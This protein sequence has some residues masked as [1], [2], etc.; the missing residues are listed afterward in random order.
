MSAPPS[1]LIGNPTSA[2]D[3]ADGI[4]TVAAN[5]RAGTD[6]GQRGIF[7]LAG[8]G[9]ASW[10]DFAEAV[11]AAS[12]KA[13]GPAARVKQIR[14]ADY[15]TAAKRPANSRLDYGKL[16]RA[17]GVRLPEWRL[18]VKEVVQRLVRAGA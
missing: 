14:T 2:F 17:H 15:P 1:S 3:L 10:A 7:H 12:A 5:L 11:F 6:S 4:L 9:E 8:A 16:A 13:G 18:S